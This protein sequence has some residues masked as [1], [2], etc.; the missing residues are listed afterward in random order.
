[1]EQDNGN[2]VLIH[3]DDPE[4]LQA[5]LAAQ[6]TFKYFWREAHWERRRIVPG[7]DLSAVK[8]AFSDGPD[9]AKDDDSPTVE[10]MWV[11]EVDFDG[12]H[13]TG[14]LANSPHWLTSIK[15]G[16]PV[17]MHIGALEDWMY[18]IRGRVYGGYTISVTRSR[19][20]SQERKQHDSAWGLDFGEPG[21]IRLV[22]FGKEAQKKE[23][24]K[25]L[26][27][28]MFGGKNNAE[29]ELEQETPDA[30]HP[31][32]VAI[33]P[34]MIEALANA[35]AQLNEADERGWTPLHHESL[36]GSAPTVEG[37]LKLGANPQAKG[38][39]GE[40]PA[41]LARSLGWS[42]VEELL[43]SAQRS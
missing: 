16:D 27:G 39:Q 31:A 8:F 2:V 5:N 34:K 14:V 41:D 35:P 40:T 20:S 13:I 24:P 12:T 21:K 23:K 15:E 33:V 19:M 36:A 43:A 9:V 42:K 38:N 25:G 18:V 10:H 29:P 32:S 17:R 4:I 26:L 28:A 3:G 37:L 6:K 22:S 11:G 1:M 30:E 7:L